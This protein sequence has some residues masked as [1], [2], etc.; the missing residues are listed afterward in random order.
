MSKTLQLIKSK[1]T[2]R[3]LKFVDKISSLSERSVCQVMTILE[4]I[5][6]LLNSE[7]RTSVGMYSSST[8]AIYFTKVIIQMLQQ[9]V[10]FNLFPYNV[11]DLAFNREVKHI[12]RE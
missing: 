3:F 2:D 7:K 11:Q 8:N 10:Y 1:G 12:L 6:E 4:L 5:C 9:E